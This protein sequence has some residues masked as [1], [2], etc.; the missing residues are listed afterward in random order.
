VSKASVFL[1]T[2]IATFLLGAQ[3]FEP[4]VFAA[5]DP[6][7][8]VN[9]NNQ[10]SI[11]PPDG[12]TTDTSGAYGTS[13][14]FYGPTLSNFRV[15]M[16]IIVESTSLSLSAYVSSAKSQLSQGLTNYQLVGRT[17]NHWRSRRLLS[18]ELVHSRGIQY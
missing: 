14:I 10:F 3:M 6:N 9:S 4:L 15:N 16:N 17:R 7:A 8:Y 5:V 13:V 2:A 18:G 1:I 11:H 12:W